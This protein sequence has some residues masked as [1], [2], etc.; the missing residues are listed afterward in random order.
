M[1]DLV[2]SCLSHLCYPH[3]GQRLRDQIVD[4]PF[5]VVSFASQLSHRGAYHLAVS[6]VKMLS[7][8]NSKDFQVNDRSV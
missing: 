6:S 5:E 1:N 7:E 8:A 3:P 2:P 4:F